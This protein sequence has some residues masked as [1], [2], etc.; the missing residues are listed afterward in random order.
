MTK[1]AVQKLLT[2]TNH[3]LTLDDF[4]LIDELDTLAKGFSGTS[5]IE[6]RLLNQPF[7]LC[8]VLFFPLTVAK[9][10][11]YAEKVAEWELSSVEQEGL[12][13]W[14]LS[15]PNASESLDLYSDP[16]LANKAVKKLSR[17]LHCTS[18]ELNTVYGKCVGNT[19]S[20]GDDSDEDVDYGGMVSSLLREYGGNPDQWLYETPIDTISDLFRACSEKAL[21]ENEQQRKT[22][23]KGGTA[24]APPPTKKLEALSHFRK[25][26]N[27]IKLAWSQDGI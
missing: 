14:L 3:Q 10:L 11:W 2:E 22:A 25:K 12:L 17:R 6:R 13:F 21:A 19:S 26:V 18:T 23:S 1:Q 27:A 8:G 5:K 9:S 16:Q 7:E 15:L 20:S 24:V 4:D